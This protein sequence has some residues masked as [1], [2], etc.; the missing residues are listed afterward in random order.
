MKPVPAPSHEVSPEVFSGLMSSIYSHVGEAAM[1]GAFV[2]GSPTDRAQLLGQLQYQPLPSNLLEAALEMGGHEVL[3]AL[4]QRDDLPPA[5]L[6]VLIESNSPLIHRKLA[7]SSQ[8]ADT[9]LRRLLPGDEFVRERIFQH[10]HASAELR[11][12]VLDARTGSGEL[13]PKSSAMERE[14]EDPR[15]ADWLMRSRS[16]QGRLQSLR[17]LPELPPAY[18]W[19]LA[20][21]V[22][23][24]AL[25][26]VAAYQAA[27]WVGPIRSVLEDAT[28][29][30]AHGGEAAACD[31]LRSG[32]ESLGAPPLY[33]EDEL[34]FLVDVE[35]GAAL[36]T[37]AP[38]NWAS[39]ERVVRSGQASL[40]GVRF[41]LG[42]DDRS[43][44]FT[45]AALAFHGDEAG[46]LEM[47]TLSDLQRAATMSGFAVAERARVIKLMVQSHTLPYRM[48]DLVGRLPMREVL[49]AIESLKGGLRDHQMERLARELADHLGDD[50]ERWH[51]FERARMSARQ[52]SFVE[53]VGA[54]N[55]EVSR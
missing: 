55:G 32:L 49:L 41:L 3:W 24:G 36:A 40:P 22:A 5:A 33:V 12:E 25:P 18:Q 54:A 44:G 50:A 15:Y 30:L 29:V 42:R 7:S 35:E 8:M 14:L 2:A 10:P 4:S 31:A 20:L 6:E 1:L 51:N 21:R 27:G 11:R 46:V 16:Q 23:E 37:T 45:T 48:L 39:L 47:C 13:L 43:A 9:H 53:A 19:R 17:A 26:I 28:A 38:L 34:R 52:I